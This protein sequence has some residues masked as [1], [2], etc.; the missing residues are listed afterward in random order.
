MI[1]I[2]FFI[3]LSFAVKPNPSYGM[4]NFK[5]MSM[6]WCANVDSANYKGSRP[7]GI[8]QLRWNQNGYKTNLLQ[9][10]GFVYKVGSKS[11]T[12]PFKFIGKNTIDYPGEYT[13][14]PVYYNMNSIPGVSITKRHLVV[15]NKHIVLEAYDI[16][17]TGSSSIT[18]NM[19]DYINSSTIS[20][21]VQGGVHS[22]TKALYFNYANDGSYSNSVV[23]AGMYDADSVSIGAALDYTPVDYFN[24]NGKLDGVTSKT[25]TCMMAG[26]QKSVTIAAGSTT[27]ITVFRGLASSVSAAQSLASEIVAKSYDSW[28][29]TLKSFSDSKFAGYK[30]PSFANDDEKKMWYSSDAASGVRPLISRPP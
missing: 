11:Y 15:P 29:A 23:I 25:A 24:T 28:L 3:T 26:F 19:M 20:S 6:H 22:A 16:K 27:R 2:F 9:G 30:T 12:D 4:H 13:F 21:K 18:F 5:D 1:A 7:A 10:D 17:N 14:T 8:C